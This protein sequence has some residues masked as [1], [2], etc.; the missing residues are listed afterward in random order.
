MNYELNKKGLLHGALIGLVGITISLMAYLISNDAYFSWRSVTVMIV[1]FVLLI[2]LGRKERRENHNGYL[3]YGAAYWYCSI[4]LF[5][6]IYLNEIF[7]IM[8]FNVFDPG[9]QDVFI[10]QSVESTEQVFMMFESDQSKIDETVLEI[11]RE[12]K[13]TFKPM[14]LLAH[15]WQFLMQAMFVGLIAALF[16]RKNPPLFEEVEEENS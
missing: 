16:L 7:Y 6:M 9:L 14:A 13:N 11:E 2:F 12:L 3:E 8:V 5:I 4:A 1:S 15:S 10:E